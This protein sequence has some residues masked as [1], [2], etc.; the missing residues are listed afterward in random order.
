[1]TNAALRV[2]EGWD[3]VP[4]P[5]ATDDDPVPDLSP[6]VDPDRLEDLRRLG[7]RT[8]PPVAPLERLCR[9]AAGV[10]EADAAS[11]TIVEDVQTTVAEHAL[12]LPD[13]KVTVP[14]DESFCA[15]AMVTGETLAIPE[16]QRHPWVRHTETARS[17][18]VI[19][20][21]GIPLVLSSGHALGALCVFSDEPRSW[22]THDERLLAD[23]A[24]TT[25]TELE[26]RVAAVDLASSLAETH[27]AR[28]RLAHAATHD[29]LTGLANRVL[30]AREV[31]DAL[32]DHGDVALLYC[33]LDGFKDVN[34]THG[35][36]VG[37]ALLVEVAGR[38]REAAGPE[39]V[40]ARLGGDEFAV[41]LRDSSPALASRTAERIRASLCAPFATAGRSLEIGAS[42]GVAT[43]ATLGRDPVDVDALLMA[44]DS[45]M[46]QAKRDGRRRVVRFDE[47]LRVAEERRRGVHD[48]LRRAIAAGRVDVVLQPDLDLRTGRVRGVEALAR[49]QGD[50]IRSVGPEEFFPA[51][52]ELGLLGELDGLVLDRVAA[53]RRAWAEA[54]SP[55]TPTLW[56]NAS[57]DQLAD[58]LLP[59]RLVALAGEAGTPLGVEV[60]EEVLADAD[61][62]E[63]L[64]ALRGAGVSVAV[65]DFGTG[66]SSFAALHR[67]PFDLLKIDR[68][69]VAGVDEDARLRTL[70]ASVLA[71]AGA[72][73]VE[74]VA[75]GVE[76]EEELA[77][78]RD[79]GCPRAAGY[80]LG[81]PLPDG[82]VLR[83]MVASGA[84][85]PLLVPSR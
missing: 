32:A 7:L 10:L 33:D 74:A 37:D 40:L 38:L 61:A 1:M 79:L 16:A 36:A 11:V 80:L 14:L 69:F 12:R 71:L 42:L 13:D 65:D 53:V 19:G 20:Y 58:G 84:A 67:L 34:D 73:G 70:V 46:F 22:T 75:E 3:D 4:L 2:I 54:S 72:L 23:L 60:T 45:A 63:V 62:V 43:S 17:G 39:A 49:L 24:A 8:A 68:S 21:L 48:G 18:G 41:M 28:E 52:A 31:A 57:A 85:H 27:A 6:L 26:L 81:R 35:H 50:D 56:V 9:L 30:L 59:E 25:A 64:D 83:S 44:A 82:P 55:A 77:V 29:A 76:T 66:Y 47:A 5:E 15:R 78:L 51:A